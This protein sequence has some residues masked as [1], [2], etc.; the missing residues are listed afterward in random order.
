MADTNLRNC[1]QQHIEDQEIYAPEELK[2]LAC[3]SAG[4]ESLD[5]LERFSR[6]E[7]LDLE[8]NPLTQ[9]STLFML[10]NLQ[11]VDLRGNSNIG[12]EELN[13]L[14]RLVNNS[15]Q[16]PLECTAENP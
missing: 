2:Q 10:A 15:S 13:R 16:F 8:N 9:I 3:S 5:G 1:I 11:Y 6:I 14:K 7:Q 4:I 12:C